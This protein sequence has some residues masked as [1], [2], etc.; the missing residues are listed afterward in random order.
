MKINPKHIRRIITLYL[1][2]FP[3]PFATIYAS[4]G[5]LKYLDF[6]GAKPLQPADTYDRLLILQDGKQEAPQ[7]EYSCDTY[8]LRRNRLL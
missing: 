2:S 7:G 5:I 8:D 3:D 4:E 6:C 1:H